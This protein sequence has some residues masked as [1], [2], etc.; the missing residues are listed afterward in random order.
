MRINI[1][2][3]DFY[4][5]AE[6]LGLLPAATYRGLQLT[7]WNTAQWAKRHA[8]RN[9]AHREALPSRVLAKRLKTY[10][11]GALESKIW[12]GFNPIEASRLG[13]P[14]KVKNGRRAGSVVIRTQGKTRVFPGAWIQ[15]SGLRDRVMHRVNGQ[16]EEIKID[17][18]AAAAETMREVE[19]LARARFPEEARQALNFAMQKMLGRVTTSLRPPDER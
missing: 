19:T 10:R 16:P 7:V 4:Q 15:K 11:K 1:F 9:L 6:A 5:V 2:S 13:K 18:S 3:R 12:L 8:A 14:Q 17:I